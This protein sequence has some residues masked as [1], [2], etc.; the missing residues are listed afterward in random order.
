MDTTELGWVP[1]LMDEEVIIAKTYPRLLSGSW[2]ERITILFDNNKVL[3]NSICDPDKHSS[4]VLFGGNEKN[5]TR[6]IEEIEKA[7]R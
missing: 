1:Y 3:V 5:E 2:G 6:L 7:S 4:V